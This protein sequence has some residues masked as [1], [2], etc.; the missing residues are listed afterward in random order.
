MSGDEGKKRNV[1]EKGESFQTSGG[2]CVAW[3]IWL[4][5]RWSYDNAPISYVSFFAALKINGTRQFFVAVER[6]TGDTRN[7]LTIDDGLA[8]LYHGDRSAN[9]RDIEGLPFSRLSGQFRGGSQKAV[10][11]SSVVAGWFLNGIGFYLDFVAAAQ[12]DAAV[13]IHSAVEFNMQPKILE[14]G[15]VNQLRALAG[16]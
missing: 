3:E 8:I 9:Q 12:I 7:L 1:A 2:I 14:L 6:A 10:D 13:G 16:R 11:T 15:I 4:L 5:L